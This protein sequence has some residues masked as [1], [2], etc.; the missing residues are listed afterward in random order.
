MPSTNAFIDPS[1]LSQFDSPPSTPA[2]SDYNDVGPSR[3]RQRTETSSEERKEARAHRNR[4][5]AQNSR[6]RRKAQFSYLERRVAELEEE[7]RQLRA[8]MSMPVPVPVTIAPPA[9][10]APV[11]PSRAEEQERERQRK[12][13]EELKERIKTLERGWD[14]VVKALAA[15]GLP[16]G[17]VPT[18]EQPKPSSPSPTLAPSSTKKSPSP[19]ITSTPAPTPTNTF[20]TVFPISPAPSTSSLDFDLDLSPAP[21]GTPPTIF[22][23]PIT[24]S[25]APIFALPTPPASLSEQAAFEPTRHSARVATVALATSLQRVGPQQ[26]NLRYLAALALVKAQS[27]PVATATR[28][29]QLMMQRWKICSGRSSSRRR[30]LRMRD[31][32][33]SRSAALPRRR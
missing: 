21:S 16:T 4:I 5:A 32:L 26:R 8:G 25:T 12:E 1:A 9:A 24:A 29:A 22:P 6:D 7:N 28:Q 17:L 30:P 31:C 33:K 3:K 19:T 11:V 23:A 2:A 18:S 20:S 10:V 15:Q 27:L 14:A 13:N